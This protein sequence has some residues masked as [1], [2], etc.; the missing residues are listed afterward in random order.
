M[1]NWLEKTQENYKEPFQ[2]KYIKREVSQ[3]IVGMSIY[4]FS[5]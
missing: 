5:L 3:G 4:G 1:H 2:Q